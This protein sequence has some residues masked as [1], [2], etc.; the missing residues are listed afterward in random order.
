M[1]PSKPLYHRRRF[2]S[3]IISH[4]VWLYFRFALSYRDVEEMMASRGVI[5]TYETVRDW[6][7][8]FGGIYA[9]RLRSRE[10]RPGDHWHLDEVYLSI[11]GKHQYL[12]RAVDQD[13]E[14]LDILV[15]PRRNKKAAKKFFWKLLK[16]LQY[17]PRAI[18]TDKL[19][20]Y[21]AAKAEIL[22]DVEHIQDKRSNN[23]AE[24]SHQPTRER[25][26]RMRGFKSA[27]HARR[28]LARFGVIASFFR[29]GWHLLTTKKYREIMRRRFMQWTEV[30]ESRFV[31]Q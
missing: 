4:C 23:R 29:P 24:N 14:V 16:G 18:I 26:R 12:W 31:F 22:P 2:P 5:L 19:G 30:I 1:R 27:G 15:Q 10:S 20:S 9:K 28:F 21:A 6:A 11:N 3:E 25:E 8:K 17:I 13:G 7:Q